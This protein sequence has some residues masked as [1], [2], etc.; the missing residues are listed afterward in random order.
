[1]TSSLNHTYFCILIK[2]KKPIAIGHHAYQIRTQL[3]CYR[4][5]QRRTRILFR[6]NQ[7]QIKHWMLSNYLLYES[8]LTFLKGYRSINCEICN[9]LML[10]KWSK[11][12]CAF[13]Y[14]ICFKIGVYFCLPAADGLDKGKEYEF[15]VKAKNTAGLGEPSGTSGPVVTKP[16]AGLSYLFAFT[17]LYAAL[18]IWI[19]LCHA[20]LINLVT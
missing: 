17:R 20:T 14:Y 5:K 15:R 9:C 8:K 18:V 10:I 1:M 7:P 19:N 11:S 12:T 16:K 13:A 3:G 6:R 2:R 4:S